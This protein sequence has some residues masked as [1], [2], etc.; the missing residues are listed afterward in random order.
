M[1]DITQNTD[2]GRVIAVNGSYIKVELIRGDGCTSCSMR[3][4]CFKKDEPAI[5]E[6]QSD[7][8][9]KKDDIVSLEISPAARVGSALL[10]FGLPLVLLFVSFI[11]AK[12]Y[13][14]EIISIGIGFA[15]MALSF[16]IIAWV[17]KRFGNKLKIEIGELHDHP[18]E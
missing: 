17:D 4:F 15:A 8:P 5:F 7:L 14:S 6:L 12:P 10:I 11:L 9:L 18:H 2:L 1:S 13:F 16:F 3:G